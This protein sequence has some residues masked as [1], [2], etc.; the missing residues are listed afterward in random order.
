MKYR[1]PDSDRDH[2]TAEGQMNWAGNL[3]KKQSSTFNF[4]SGV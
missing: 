3:G 2:L 4:L 1:I